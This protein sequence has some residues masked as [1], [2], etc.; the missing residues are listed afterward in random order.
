V[1]A[2][3]IELISDQLNLP[4][5]VD[6]DGRTAVAAIPGA[7]ASLR[8]SHNAA[9]LEVQYLEASRSTAVMRLDGSTGAPR[10]RYREHVT[11]VE[12]IRDGWWW[13]W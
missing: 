12:A 7:G 8:A 4:V 10:L 3:R 2:Q 9:A 6:N 1:T 13:W 5:D 11:G